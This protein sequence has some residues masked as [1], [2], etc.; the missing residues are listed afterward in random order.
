[1]IRHMVAIDNQRG[2]AKNNKLPWKLPTDEQY[3]TDMTKT[4]G[5]IVLMG[6]TTY[7]ETVLKP[8]E[9]RQNFVLTHDP[10]YHAVGATTVTDVYA[11]L[12]MYPE[13]WV[14]G[15]AKVFESTLT[16]ADE[17]YITEIEADF[18]CDTFYPEFATMFE[19]R[20]KG[21]P[22]TENGLSYRFNLYTPSKS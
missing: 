7:E 20:K 8:L 9:G 21:E 4:H 22:R 15:G 17:L 3:F 5:G 16:R 1:M 2:I 13:V 12:D 19:L 14:I 10:D 11:F 18:D 6:R